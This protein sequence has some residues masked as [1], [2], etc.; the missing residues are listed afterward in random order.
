MLRLAKAFWDLALW[1]I[2]PAQLPASRFLLLLVTLAVALVEVVGAL[3]PGAATDSL[4]TRVASGVALG[5]AV[6]LLWAWAILA[7]MQRRQRFLQTASALLGVGVLAELLLYPLGSLLDLLGT[8]NP[9]A[10]PIGLLSLGGLVWYLLA[11][12]NIWKAA[13]ESGLS[14]GIAISVGYLALSAALDRLLLPD[15]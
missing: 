5:V 15:A 2:S 13:L 1:R 3:L 10:I 7:L 8:D 14:L 6:P 12:A 11:C 4:A 9:V